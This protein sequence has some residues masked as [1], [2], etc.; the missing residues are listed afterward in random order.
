MLLFD[1]PLLMENESSITI[2]ED[3]DCCEFFCSFEP[4]RGRGGALKES[5]E[6][7]EEKTKKCHYNCGISVGDRLFQWRSETPEALANLP[8]VLYEVD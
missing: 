8:P 6:E 1:K 3:G 5:V 4:L 2:S 7:G